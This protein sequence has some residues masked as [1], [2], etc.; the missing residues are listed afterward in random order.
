[1]SETVLQRCRAWLTKQGYEGIIIP[2]GD[3]WQHE[4]PPPHRRMLY[5]ITGFSGSAGIAV[6]TATHAIVFTDGRYQ[7]QAHTELTDFSLATQTLHEWFEKNLTRGHTWA[8]DA[9]YHTIETV[10]RWRHVFSRHDASLTALSPHPLSQ[11]TAT[12]DQHITPHPLSAAGVKHED[13]IHRL[14]QFLTK[15][16]WDGVFIG[17]SASVSWLFNI[18]GDAIAYSPVVCGRAMVMRDGTALLWCN[19]DTPPLSSVVCGRAM[20]MRDGT[21]L[22]WRNDDTPPLSSVVRGRAM[23]MRDGTALP[24]R[25]DDTPPLSSVVRVA[26]QEHELVQACHHRRIAIARDAPYWFYD[27]IHKVAKTVSV[28]DD[29]CLEARAQKNETEIA[30]AHDAHHKDAIA[31]IAT[32]HELTQDANWD[33]WRIAQ[34]VHRWRHKDAAARM[35]SFPTIAAAGENAA[36][37]HYHTKPPHQR[38]W[39][40]GEILLLDSGCHYHSAT[41][42]VTRSL[43]RGSRANKAIYCVHYTLVLKALLAVLRAR[44]PSDAPAQQ[45]D[46]LART[47]LANEGCDYPHGT[48]HGVGSCLTVHEGPVAINAREKR[49]LPHHMIVSVEP[50]YYEAHSHGIR[51]ENLVLTHHEGGMTRLECLTLVPYERNLIDATRLTVQEI[52][53]IDDYHATIAARL[54][55]HLTAKQKDFLA[56]KCAPL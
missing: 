13:K 55:P 45:W 22:P 20:V 24:W 16:D 36:I 15:H 56:E 17:D 25:N 54:M 34:C 53:Q 40:K 26:T 1:M 21:A 46:G 27:A 6:I 11:E 42:D 7:L 14:V 4:F 23:V 35:D 44:L 41:T 10:Q 33:E 8:Y 50:G 48:G 51:L 31:L 30:G 19:G 18:R 28:V 5:D 32:W 39:H 37:V 12:I 9:R 2:H 29:P 52:K 47:I 49:P 3:E 43:L 38:E